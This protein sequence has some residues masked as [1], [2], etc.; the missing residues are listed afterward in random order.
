[1]AAIRKKVP[2]W[3]ENRRKDLF[4]L[5]SAAEKSAAN[6]IRRLGYNISPQHIFRTPTR[7]FYADI[8]IPQLSTVVEIDGGYHMT[9]EQRRK[10]RNRTASL[11]RLG[12]RHVVRLSNK[13]ARK[14][15]K[16]RAKLSLVSS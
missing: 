5:R 10:D 11:R 6:I 8:F 7:T 13:D 1:M 15:T 3:A 14:P 12:V 2:K 4:S 9:E 16:I